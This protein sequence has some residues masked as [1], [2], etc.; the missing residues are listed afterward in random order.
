MRIESRNTREYNMLTLGE[1]LLLWKDVE[2]DF[3]FILSDHNN[4]STKNKLGKEFGSACQGRGKYRD[5]ENF[6]V[7]E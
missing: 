1:F 2:I 5:G 3:V 7:E 4:I 6:I